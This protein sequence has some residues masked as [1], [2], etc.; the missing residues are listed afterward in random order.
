MGQFPELRTDRLALREFRR[1]DAQALFEVLS[2]KDVTRYLDTDVDSIE[3][4]E[5]KVKRRMDLFHNRDGIRWGITLPALG[6]SVIGSCSLYRLNRL[7]FSCEIG[8]ELHHL[9]WRQGLMAEALTKVID[10]A[11][12]DGFFFHLNRIEALTYPVNRA[13]TAL[14]EKLGFQE[15]GIRRE[16]AYWRNR[17]VDLQCYSLLRRDLEAC[18]DRVALQQ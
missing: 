9:Y 11:F 3:D 8:Y 13:S 1:T 16:F 10:F 2:R 17:F 4:A 14:L 7:W 6:D 15:E 18:Q 12:G 5:N